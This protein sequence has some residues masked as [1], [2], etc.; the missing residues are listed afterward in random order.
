MKWFRDFCVIV[1]AD[2][3]KFWKSGI[4]IFPWEMAGFSLAVTT[5]GTS[6]S[7]TV[8]SPQQLCTFPVKQLTL[9]TAHTHAALRNTHV[10]LGSSRE[11]FALKVAVSGASP[12][13]TWSPAGTLLWPPWNFWA[14]PPSKQGWSLTRW[15][16]KLRQSVPGFSLG[17]FF[18]F[19]LHPIQV[20]A[21]CNPF[22]FWA[23]HDKSSNCSCAVHVARKDKLR[24]LFCRARRESRGKALAC[25]TV[26]RRSLR[27]S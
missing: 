9:L 14:W 4:D 16:I 7:V 2:S 24:K 22:F 5:P 17:L 18:F 6:L 12:W 20:L 21:F 26:T 27:S 23:L 25:F 3:P 19:P 10:N 13:D 15:L 1:V 11:R 8:P